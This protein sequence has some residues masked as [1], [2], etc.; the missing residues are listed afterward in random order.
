MINDGT[1]GGQI[2]PFKSFW[3]K[4]LRE[5]P[6]FGY[7]SNASKTIL[8]VKKEED[9]PKAKAIFKDTGLNIV[10]SDGDRHLGAVLGSNEFRDSFVQKKISS[11][12][13]DVENLSEIAQEEPQIA[14]SAFTKGLS[15]RWSFVQR[16]IGG[17][18]KLFQP[19]EDAIRGQLIPAILGRQINDEERDM[20]ALPL[21]YGGLGIQN[22]VQTSDREYDASKKI[23]DQLAGLIYHQDQDLSKLD[24]GQLVK[25]KAELKTQ[26]EDRFSSEKIRLEKH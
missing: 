2:V 15:H 17:I 23:T 24:R 13:K 5:G 14:F 7:S 11:L 3:N 1:A 25:K 26:K 19:L 4:L 10:K 21:R 6:K 16:T 20:L 12:V 9:L 18:S 8:I 22:P